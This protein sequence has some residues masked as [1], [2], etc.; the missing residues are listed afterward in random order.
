LRIFIVPDFA[1]TVSAIDAGLTR[2]SSP[3]ILA[4]FF[5]AITSTAINVESIRTYPGRYKPGLY[6]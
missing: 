2:H 6:G 1:N 4:M 5:N 3:L